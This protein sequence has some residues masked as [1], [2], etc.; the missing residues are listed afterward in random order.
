MA[1]GQRPISNVVDITNYVMLLTGQPLHA[2]DLD[3]VAGGRLVVRRARDGETMETLDGSVRE[4]D[5]EMVV[6][7]DAEGPTSIAGVMGGARSEVGEGTTRVLL[8]AA[9]WNGPNI[10]RTSLRLGLRSEASGRFEKQLQPEQAMEAQAVA[11]ALL[12]ELCGARLVPGTIDVGGPG[13]E[14]P[15]IRLRHARMTGL[16]GLEIPPA[17]AAEILEALEFE[18]DASRRRPGRPA[19]GTPPRRR[20]A[21]GR[22]RRGGRAH[23][24]PRPPARDPPG[25]QRG[26]RQAGARAAPAPSRAG[27]ARRPRP[28][29][30]R[31]LRAS[32]R[33]T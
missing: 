11:S 15:V 31:R 8:E 16:L 3:R 12:V 26:D 25:A 4:L 1:A 33:P 23:L 28:L 27:P 22:R 2:F 10:H 24:R 13:P 32:W 21:R 19:A 17:R 20:D 30:D 5:S 7:D 6:I 29:R 9:T 14:P 18:V